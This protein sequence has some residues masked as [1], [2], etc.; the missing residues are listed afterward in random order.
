[1]GSADTPAAAATV[2]GPTTA[3]AA[4]APA[5]PT[6]EEPQGE[7]EEEDELILL[8]DSRPFRNVP[9]WASSGREYEEADSSYDFNGAPPY[10]LSVAPMV[11]R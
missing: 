1:M 11:G 2:E 4:N 9:S 8:G 7:E 10:T 3:P 5:A 6:Q